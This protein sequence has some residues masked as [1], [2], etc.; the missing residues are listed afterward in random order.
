MCYSIGSLLLVHSSHQ[1]LQFNGDQRKWSSIIQE[2]IDIQ[3]A[4]YC[5]WSLGNIVPDLFP[6]VL[7]FPLIGS[8]FLPCIR[9]TWCFEDSFDRP[10]L[11]VDKHKP[12]SI[13]RNT[14]KGH[15]IRSIVTNFILAIND[16]MLRWIH[17]G[18]IICS[19]YE[20]QI[21]KI[22]FRYIF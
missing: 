17:C 18:L 4:N 13:A 22:L 8:N 16:P 10:R 7:T 11:S 21:F 12:I 9:R 1:V 19:V 20:L 15:G 2:I 14:N 3:F 6:I 5:Y